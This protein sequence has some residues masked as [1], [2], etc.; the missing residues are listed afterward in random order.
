MKNKVLTLKNDIQIY[1]VDEV[2]YKNHRYVYGLQCD[3]KLG[4]ISNNHILLEAKINDGRLVVDNIDDFATASVIN[5][6][7]LSRFRD[8]KAFA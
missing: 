8:N 1:V 7:F 6:I 5:N 4:E 2:I 3:N